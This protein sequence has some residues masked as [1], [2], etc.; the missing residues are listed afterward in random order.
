MRVWVGCTSSHSHYFQKSLSLINT[1]EETNH[2]Y[3][4]LI[5]TGRRSLDHAE[6]SP[7]LGHF[8]AHVIGYRPDGGMTLETMDKT[9]L[10]ARPPVIQPDSHADLELTSL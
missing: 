1:S 8:Q 2:R 7:F 9:A 3:K 5:L 4:V 6:R 10:P